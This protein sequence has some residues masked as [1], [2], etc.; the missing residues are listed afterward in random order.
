[1]GWRLA[2]AAADS[3][4]LLSGEDALTDYQFGKKHLHHPFCKVC[5][6]RSFSRGTGPDGV[7][8]V[9]INVRCLEGVDAE[10]F[11]AIHYDGKS[12]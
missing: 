1:M 2:F 6:I 5:G 4:K 9:A 3:F 12:A 8:T 11:E 10:K 7:P